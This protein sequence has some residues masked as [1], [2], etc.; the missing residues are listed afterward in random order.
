MS[1]LTELKTKL[2]DEYI[3]ID[4]NNKIRSST[5]KTS[6]INRGFLQIQNDWQFRWRENQALNTITTVWWNREYALPSDFI[7]VD[8]MTYNWS[9]LYKISKERVR[10]MNST[11]TQ[12][13]PNNYYIYWSYV[14]FDPIPNTTLTILMDYFKR[15]PTITDTVDSS[16][17]VA[18][19]DAICSYAAYVALNS[20]EKQ[21][22]AMMMLN[23][24]QQNLSMLLNSY[25]YDDMNISFWLD[26]ATNSYRDNVI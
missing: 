14:G 8:Q 24:Y 10:V 12:A 20:I 15:L 25:I 9:I 2:N 21:G 18:F 22:K 3:K 6:F 7:R 26:R 13:T 16:L 5:E 1:T 4:P 17:P 19:D 23:D 11:N